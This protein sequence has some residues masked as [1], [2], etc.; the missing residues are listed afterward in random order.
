MK[1][2]KNISPY[3]EIKMWT[4][5]AKP[6][7][8]ILGTGLNNEYLFHRLWWVNS[9]RIHCNRFG[10]ADPKKGT[11]QN[12][13]HYTACLCSHYQ[14]RMNYLGAEEGSTRS[15]GEDARDDRRTK[16]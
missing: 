7:G 9:I 2:E 4:S 5:T 1:A 12:E 15:N 6:N 13:A 16:R 10:L 8:V 11:N 3:V 14:E